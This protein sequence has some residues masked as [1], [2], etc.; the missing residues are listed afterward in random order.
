MVWGTPHFRKPPCS[1]QP[2]EIP[3]EN[4]HLA[5]GRAEATSGPGTSERTLDQHLAW[6]TIQLGHFT[7]KDRCMF[8]GPRIEARKL[9]IDYVVHWFLK[10]VIGHEMHHRQYDIGWHANLAWTHLNKKKIDV[11][12]KYQQYHNIQQYHTWESPK[13]G[14]YAP[15]WQVEEGNNDKPT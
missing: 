13:M 4:V 2:I 9:R 15:K 11:A 12:N 1:L 14:E 5:D 3:K 7:G 6:G 8:F 10:D